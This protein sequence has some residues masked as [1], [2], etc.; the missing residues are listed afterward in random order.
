MAPRP[1]ERVLD[2]CTG[3][4]EMAV[5]LRR[6]APQG[7][8]D[9][10]VGHGLGEVVHFLWVGFQVEKHFEAQLPYLS[11]IVAGKPAELDIGEGN[12]LVHHHQGAFTGGLDQCP[13]FLAG[14]A[15]LFFCVSST[16]FDAEALPDD[17]QKDGA[18]NE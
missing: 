1:G 13:V 6:L 4:G 15:K 3:T 12:F 7:S 9:F 16:V 14:A 10:A 2:V 8:E 18:E 17:K 11:G 5:L